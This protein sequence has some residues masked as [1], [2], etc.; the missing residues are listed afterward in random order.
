VGKAFGFEKDHPALFEGKQVAQLGVYFSYQTRKYTFF[1]GVQRGYY[2]DWR[3]TVEQLF[4]KGI[5]PH[6]VFA[7]PPDAS[8]YPLILVPSPLAMSEEEKKKLDTYLKNG[9][10][11]LVYGPCA[12]D[13]CDDGVCYPASPQVSDPV[14]AFSA[15]PNGTRI[16]LPDWMTKT[17]FPKTDMAPAWR[18]VRRG[19]FYNP[20]RI[21]SGEITDSLLAL[22]RQYMKPMPVEILQ[23]DGYLITAFEDEDAFVIRMLAADYDTDIDH[24]LDEMRFH[25]SRVNYINFV[26][27]AGVTQ[28]LRLRTDRL[29]EVFTPFNASATVQM[30]QGICSVSLPEKTSFIILR[31]PKQ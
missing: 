6:T 19:L 13:G 31:I 24:K 28:E 1:G 21:S 22:T 26:Q 27:A 3:R 12:L 7:F 15:V 14:A 10:V 20:V 29:P 5:S 17:E 2:S 18:E 9:G 25:R 23:A 16:T 30:E 8:E 4:A 11:A